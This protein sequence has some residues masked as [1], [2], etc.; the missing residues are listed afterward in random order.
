MVERTG[1]TVRATTLPNGQIFT[2]IEFTDEAEAG[3]IDGKFELG[4]SG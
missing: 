1:R 4:G 3:V 2:A